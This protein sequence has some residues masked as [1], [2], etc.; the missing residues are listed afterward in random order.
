LRHTSRPLN[1]NGEQ[2]VKVWLA[3]IRN[4]E[5]FVN[6]YRRQLDVWEAG[7]V[8]GL[9]LGY[10][11]FNQNEIQSHS[12]HKVAFPHTGEQR[13]T[14][15][16]DPGIYR[17][18]GVPTPPAPVGG[19][20]DGPLRERLDEALAAVVDRGWSLWLFDPFVGADLGGGPID[21]ATRLLDEEVR[22]RQAARMLD[23]I[24][25]Y[26]MATGVIIDGPAWGYEIGDPLDADSPVARGK[27]IFNELGPAV[28]R[29]A[30]A[31]GYDYSAL[32]AARDALQARLHALDPA[33]VRLLGA[34]GVTG[35]LSLLG[36]SGLADWLAFRIDALTDFTAYMR[37]AINE[38]AG[39]PVQLAVCPRTPAVA[40]LAGYD[41]HRIAEHADVVMAKLYYWHRGFD[42]LIGT[43]W[44]WAATLTDWNPGLSVSDACR[45]M[46]SIFGAAVPIVDALADFD[47][48]LT[49]AYL[50]ELAAAEAEQ[51]VAGVAGRA[52]VVPW[53]DNGRAPHDGDPLTPEHLQVTLEAAEQAGIE[54]VTYLNVTNLTAASWTTLSRYCG[55]AYDPRTTDWRPDDR[56]T[57]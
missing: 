19:E 26:P 45:V 40:P 52:Q 21:I 27:V 9:V 1:Q 10:M 25:A 32:A 56:P 46:R 31:L 48:L 6:D 14:F 24:A 37:A 8:D 29:G 54:H 5:S 17:D 57:A 44:R 53:V 35:G 33:R 55:A 16:P 41:Y 43:W 39:R 36:G 30:G 51:A 34:G 47:F 11:Q 13:A 7:G 2:T 23:V 42:G 22:A 18:F 3:H 12:G 50:R 28:E 38:H 49:P 4:L 20:D 15:D